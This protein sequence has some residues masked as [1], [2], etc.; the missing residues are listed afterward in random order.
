MTAS[1]EEP[2]LGNDGRDARASSHEEEMSAEARIAESERVVENGEIALEWAD[3]REGTGISTE[4]TLEVWR[5]GT[6]G[7][8]LDG[9]G[10]G[11]LSEIAA[12]GGRRN[13]PGPLERGLVGREADGKDGVLTRD[14]SA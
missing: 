11:V 4:K 8:G 1:E 6:V 2:E 13:G 3:E 10:E 9:D 14:V 12:S 7:F 5:D